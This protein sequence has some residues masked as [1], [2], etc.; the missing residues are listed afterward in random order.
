MLE[1]RPTDVA[2][3]V[4]HDGWHPGTIAQWMRH[5]DGWWA[6]VRWSAPDGRR[7]DTFPADR[8]RPVETADG[9]GAAPAH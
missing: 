2:C 6:W 3:E 4:E 5:A 9:H 7:I 8:V 1:V